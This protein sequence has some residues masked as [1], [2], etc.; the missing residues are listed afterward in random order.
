MLDRYEI[1]PAS[2]LPKFLREAG[3]DWLITQKAAINE[4]DARIV[5]GVKG[6]RATFDDGRW[7]RS[8]E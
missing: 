8:S 6:H 2:S 7:N 1:V 4:R 5:I 3:G